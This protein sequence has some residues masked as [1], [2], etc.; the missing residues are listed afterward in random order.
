M[1]VILVFKVALDLLTHS[2]KFVFFCSM[3]LVYVSF[4]L[5]VDTFCCL[6]K[7]LKCN[8][9]L[10]I[11]PTP[12][13]RMFE[14]VVAYIQ[15]LLKGASGKEPTCQWRRCKRPRFDPWTRKILW[16]RVQQPTPVFLPRESHGQRSL[17]GY[18]L[19]GC[20]ESDMTEAS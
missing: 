4:I 18:S 15:G 14:Q 11:G 8:D 9:L 16:R 20:K 13:F 12:A 19:Q 2:S 17:V 1:K 7:N 3:Q 10:H 5:S 6:Q